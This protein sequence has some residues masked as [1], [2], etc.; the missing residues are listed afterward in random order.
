MS[1]ERLPPLMRRP[2]SASTGAELSNEAAR[3][4]AEPVAP[5]GSLAVPTEPTQPRTA[6][7]CGLG[8]LKA[9]SCAELPLAGT[10]N[11]STTK[12]QRRPPIDRANIYVYEASSG[13]KVALY[14]DGAC[15]VTMDGK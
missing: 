1:L 3:I 13:P 7:V 2:A 6:G 10:Q 8:V 4:H 5:S 15:A 14:F 9:G 11:N 12:R